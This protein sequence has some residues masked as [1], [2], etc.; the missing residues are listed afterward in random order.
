[1]GALTVACWAVV[2]VGALTVADCGDEYVEY[3]VFISGV[4]AA[5]MEDDRDCT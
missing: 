1:M 2:A 4:C 5:D 3:D